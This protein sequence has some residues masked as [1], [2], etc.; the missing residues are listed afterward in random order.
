MAFAS[1]PAA[2]GFALAALGVVVLASQQGGFFPSAWRAGAVAF[3]AAAAL[4]WLWAP[5]RR[6]TWQA[7]APPALLAAL[8]LWSVASSV[9][10]VAPGA[11]TLDAQRTL[12]YLTA[13][14]AFA[15][16]GEGLTLG[17]LG[18]STIVAA[19]ALG[20][21]LVHGTTWDTY[22]GR[23]LTGPLGYAN[24]LAAL[25]A[26]G[27][28]VAVALALERRRP[29]F[30]A[31][32]VLL[33]PALALTGSRGA[34][35]ASAAGAAVAVALVRGRPL[36]AAAAAALSGALLVLLLLFTPAAAGDRAAYWHVARD[37]AAAHPLG[38][39]GAGTFAI[40]YN[41]LPAAHDAHSLYLQAAAEL[42]A[43]GLLLVV[44]LVALPLAVALRRRL[45]APAAG[46]TVFALHAG[47]DWDWQLPAVTV[48]AL[49]LAAAATRRRRT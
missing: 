13:A 20:G 15:A 28:V 35:V 41:R 46:L 47:L 38:G 19:W 32:L 17:V 37:V 8:G 16:A 40:D 29:V 30:A 7:V 43:V 21:R 11:S 39:T 26:I 27:A 49:A 14:V 5:E 22:E 23:L 33:L 42:G 4:V 45:V 36:L 31:P 6:W 25:V 1:P 44:A 48:A 2:R 24:G 18:G 9:W 3:A 10:S 12:L 34:F